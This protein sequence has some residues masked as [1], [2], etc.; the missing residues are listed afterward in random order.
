MIHQTVT[1]RTG[2]SAA[3]F[4]RIVRSPLSAMGGARVE[5]F[6]ARIGDS[7]DRAESLVVY[8]KGSAGKESFTV[9]HSLGKTGGTP[10]V[11]RLKTESRD[12]VIEAFEA[13]LTTGTRPSGDRWEDMSDESAKSKAAIGQSLALRVARILDRRS[14]D[15]A[16][17]IAGYFEGGL[18]PNA[19]DPTSNDH[20]LLER[21]FMNGWPEDGAEIAQVFIERGFRPAENPQRL[22][23]LFRSLFVLADEPGFLPVWKAII[24]AGGRI[25]ISGHGENGGPDR[26]LLDALWEEMV[27]VEEKGWDFEWARKAAASIVFAE[28]VSEG[29]D[30]TQAGFYDEAIGKSV[31]GAHYIPS[32]DGPDYELKKTQDECEQES[33]RYKGIVA[34]DLGDTVLAAENSDEIYCDP[35][36]LIDRTFASDISALLPG[37]TGK[38][39]AGF[40]FEFMPIVYSEDRSDWL[41]H[42]TVIFEDGT[43]LK[44]GNYKGEQIFRTFRKDWGRFAVE[45]DGTV[46]C[47][48][49]LD[50][51][52]RWKIYDFDRLALRLQVMQMKKEVFGLDDFMK[53]AW[54]DWKKAQNRPAADRRQWARVVME[55][56]DP[57]AGEFLKGKIAEWMDKCPGHDPKER[58]RFPWGWK[59]DRQIAAL[60]LRDLPED[61]ALQLGVEWPHDPRSDEKN[62]EEGVKLKVTAAEATEI[63]KEKGWLI[64]FQD[65]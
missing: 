52:D 25:E 44:F 3:D 60:R 63:A 58:E 7:A 16:P 27:S 50:T 48:E 17:L 13:L 61:F 59:T 55:G 10:R 23:N 46:V 11:L 4:D 56:R 39:I 54:R 5:F 21:L 51:A 38:K 14:P 18:D 26:P 22:W 6:L 29:E 19:P 64:E 8:R 9:E 42:S 49:G 24:R 65:A 41:A 12:E 47:P 1:V 35:T 36:V 30:I 57:V 31:W 43:A 2:M 33:F 15:R 20:Y 37:L 28:L 62:F 34:L 32:A 45:P 53:K 40:S